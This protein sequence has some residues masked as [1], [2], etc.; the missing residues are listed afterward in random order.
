MKIRTKLIVI[1]TL[2]CLAL[3]ILLAIVLSWHLNRVL[4][5]DFKNRGVV[6][7]RAIGKTLIYHIFN[8]DFHAVREAIKGF[9]AE[10]PGVLYIFVVDF[11]RRIIA[12]T[13]ESGFPVALTHH[14]VYH[15]ITVSRYAT[16]WGDITDVACPL[17]EGQDAHIHIGLSESDIHQALQTNL[18]IVLGASVF[19]A[20]FGIIATVPFTR[21]M[22]KTLDDL[23]KAANAI[24]GGERD[25]TVSTRE[26]GE[27]SLLAANFNAMN[28]E[29]ARHEK[30]LLAER[31]K[32]KS[33]LDNVTIGIG[34][35]D[36]KM[37]VLSLN[38]QMKAWFPHIDQLKRPLCYRF[39]NVPPREEICPYCPT[40]EAFKDGQIH[41]AETG[42][43]SA[44]GIR[45][46]R[47][48]AIPV[49]EAG[50]RIIHVIE[51]VE[52]ITKQKK[53]EAMLRYNAGVQTALKE[54]SSRLIEESMDI[55]EIAHLILTRSQ[56]ITGS[57][58]VFAGYIDPATGYF[59]SPTLSLDVWE[60]CRVT[61]KDMIFREFTGLWG[62]VLREGRPLLTNDPNNDPRS[63][64]IPTGHMPIDRFLGVPC[65]Y[66]GKLLGM[67]GL[68]NPPQDYTEQD[69]A[70]AVQFADLLAIALQRHYA[71]EE[72]IRTERQLSH[73]QKMEAV[74]TLAGG[75][76]HDFNNILTG[77]IGYANM[78]ELELKTVPK[79]FKKVRAISVNAERAATLVRQILAFSRR[80]LLDMKTFDLKELVGSLTDFLGRIIGEHIRLKTNLPPD[81][82]IVKADYSA[83]EQII[84]NLVVN[85]RD[86]MPT[87]GEM[88]IEASSVNLTAKEP[89]APPWITPGSYVLLSVGDTGIGM[90]AETRKHIFDPF[91]TTKKTGTGL[92]LAMVYGL[93]EQHKGFIDVQ[94]E[95]GKGTIF[96]I[97]L[98]GAAATTTQESGH[99]PKIKAAGDGTET[100]LICEDDEV[101][102]DL[103]QVL[104]T[105]KGYTVYVAASGE[106]ALEL[107][108]RHKD[109]IDL[110]LLDTVLP[111][112]S[113]KQVSGK[114]RTVMPGIKILFTS[115]YS[116]DS[117]YQDFII[118]EDIN[119]IKKPFSPSALCLRIREV[120]DRD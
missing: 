20:L 22:L 103:A 18:L 33:I 40:V 90:D 84:T 7:S 106:E 92:G 120:L 68:A 107:F 54:T 111:G 74:G 79:Q 94:S 47:I 76:A 28:A 95:L 117:I 35:I 118:E 34:V 36:P 46:Y 88:T 45:N 25:V 31:G 85:A 115:G 62:W 5:E 26:K 30:D 98:P 73:A 99:A 37:R 16:E 69:M 105:E 75:I 72:R 55:K 70:V 23:T 114:I 10:Q 91:F 100:I 86:A 116:A 48:T 15:G 41:I 89:K 12:H 56:E 96:N 58:Y 2:T 63:A 80:Q 104:L 14:P 78:L 51:L 60:Q 77:I 119:F 67:M 112:M 93:V 57:R 11:D 32:L 81:A 97:Y 65:K 83:V 44:E 110:V 19:F 101:V 3:A 113:G 17:I 8:R 102:R 108:H 71:E 21:G 42:I 53:D 82:L 43:P 1:H 24:A 50:E 61:D 27:I 66:K 59:V 38:R 13:F 109:E 49:I 87:G 6:M 29:L 52:D 4:E 39:F 9:K 64:G